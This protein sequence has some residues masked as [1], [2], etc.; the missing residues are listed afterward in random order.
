M[1][2]KSHI[3]GFWD[4]V[5]AAVMKS[6]LT[7]NDIARMIGCNRKTLYRSEEQNMNCLYVA[8]FCAVTK[9]DSNWLLGLKE[10]ES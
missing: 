6:G 7:K 8:K 3:R 9:T 10:I 1:K 2:K 4:R 5:D